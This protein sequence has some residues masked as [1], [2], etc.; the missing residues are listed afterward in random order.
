MTAL[1]IFKRVARL[2]GLLGLTLVPL[3]SQATA[4]AVVTDFQGRSTITTAGRSVD[5]AILSDI[6]PGAQAQLAANASLVVLYLADGSEYQIK[7]PAQVLFRA[8][9]PEVSQ[10]APAVRRPAPAAGSLRIKAAAVGQGAIVMRSLGSTRIRLVSGNGTLVLDAQ[11]ELSWV[12]PAPDLRYSL[13]VADDMGRSLLTAEVAATAFQLP[14]ALGLRDGSTYTWEVSGRG[15]DGRKYSGRGEFGVAT[16]PLRLQVSAAKGLAD[17]VMSSQVALA[18]W[19]EQQEL[20]DE[21]RK[22]WRELAR[23]RPNEAQLKAMA[24]R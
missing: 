3:L 21:A 22:V 11:P 8:D 4:M 6:Q 1:T 5:A 7:G 16:A 15:P 14:A 18:L 13:D 9:R 2:V 12:A 20:R 10:G 24:E 17:A 23:Q 19:L